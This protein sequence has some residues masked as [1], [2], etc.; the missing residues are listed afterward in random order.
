MHERKEETREERG[1]SGTHAR[2]TPRW[3]SVQYMYLCLVFL[4]R[5]LRRG[6]AFFCTRLITIVKYKT[7]SRKFGST[8][9]VRGEEF[10]LKVVSSNGKYGIH[11]P[12]HKKGHLTERCSGG[13]ITNSTPSGTCNKEV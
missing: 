7:R 9:M 13:K 12:Q 11:E 6:N 8:K 2:L 4:I 5:V 1:S 3:Y 10:L